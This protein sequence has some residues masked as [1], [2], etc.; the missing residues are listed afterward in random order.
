LGIF[1]IMKYWSM[2][3]SIS[4][5]FDWVAWRAVINECILDIV[6]LETVLMVTV[7]RDLSHFSERFGKSGAW[8]HQGDLGNSTQNVYP[9]LFSVSLCNS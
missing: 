6:N 1:F 5:L 2:I 7:V 9:V 3:V 4:L 8:K